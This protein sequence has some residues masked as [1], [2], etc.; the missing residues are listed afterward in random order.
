MV[1]HEN[2]PKPEVEEKTEEQDKADMLEQL[3]K[4]SYTVLALAY[5][6]AKG[7]ELGGE[8]VT[9]LWKVTTMQNDALNRAYRKGFQDCYQKMKELQE[10]EEMKAIIE[11]TRR[12]R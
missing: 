6:Y 8:D 12:R 4:E 9:H 5:L 3:S 7:Y 2:K 11:K 1:I 10:K